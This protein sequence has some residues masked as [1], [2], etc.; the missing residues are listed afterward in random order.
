[1]ATLDFKVYIQ[2]LLMV[3][4]L[5][6]LVRNLLAVDDDWTEVVTR[7]R[8]AWNVWARLSQIMER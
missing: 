3:S 1:M 5:R 4:L 7:I 6:Y 2:P 8:N